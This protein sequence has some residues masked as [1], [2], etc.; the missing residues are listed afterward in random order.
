MYIIR[1]ILSL[2]N[3]YS[4][5]RLSSLVPAILQ[6]MDLRCRKALF[7]LFLENAVP[8]NLCGMK[9]D[10]VNDA[11]T[12]RLLLMCWLKVVICHMTRSLVALKSEYKYNY[13]I[14]H[15]SIKSEFI[16]DLTMF[17]LRFLA[18]SLLAFIPTPEHHTTLLSSKVTDN[19]IALPNKSSQ[20]YEA[21]HLPP[22]RSEHCVIS[23]DKYL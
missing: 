5:N 15:A 16:Q 22:D 13:L 18:K 11:I 8:L 6:N 23:Y 2:F 17:V 3:P 19:N 14:V 21:S 12:V 1:H 4:C 9:L 10:R 20:S 7:L